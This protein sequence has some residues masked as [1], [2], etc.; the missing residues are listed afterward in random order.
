MMS[1]EDRAETTD[2]AELIAALARGWEAS[3]GEESC[4]EYQADAVLESFAV[5]RKPDA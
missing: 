1:S 2:R 4:F 3:S 5:S